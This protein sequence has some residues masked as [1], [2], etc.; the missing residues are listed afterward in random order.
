MT[1]A[2]FLRRISTILYPRSETL[3]AF[4]LRVDV[5]LTFRVVSTLLV[6]AAVLINLLS[7]HRAD[8]ETLMLYAALAASAMHG[9]LMGRRRIEQLR[10]ALQQKADELQR[11]LDLSLDMIV[12]LTRNGV[13]HTVNQA[14]FA[15]LGYRPE[16]LAGLHFKDVVHPSGRDQWIREG[17]ALRQNKS[18]SGLQVLCTRKDGQMV[19][20]EW[21]AAP[22]A[23]EGLIYAVA[24][25]ITQRKEQAFKLAESE[26]RLRS[27][28]TYNLDLVASIDLSGRVVS[29]NP[30]VEA[31]LGY[32]PDEVVGRSF[33]EFLASDQVDEMVKL[34]QRS[35]ERQTQSFQT[36]LIHSDGSRRLVSSAS[37]P[38]IVDGQLVGVYVIVRDITEQRETEQR[39]RDQERLYRLLA[40]NSRDLI[41]LYDPS[42]KPQFVSPASLSMMGYTP[43]EY[44]RLSVEAVVHPEDSQRVLETRTRHFRGETGTVTFR[45]QRKDGEYIWIETL[46]EPIFD[47]EGCLL[48]VLS[49]SRD[50]T[51]R[52]R[53]R[54]QLEASEQRFRSL[55][56]N[57]SDVVMLFDLKGNLV[58][59]NAASEALTGYSLEELKGSAYRRHL[60]A[61]PVELSD[62]V[63]RPVQPG[64]VAPVEVLYRHKIGTL[65]RF[66]TT[67]VPL[68]IEG[69]MQGFFSVGRDVTDMR[70]SEERVR[71]LA[72]AGAVLASSLDYS[73]TLSSMASLVVEHLADCCAIDMLGTDGQMETVALVHRQPEIAESMSL[74]RE[75]VLNGPDQVVPAMTV[76]RTGQ[77]L[78]ISDLNDQTIAWKPSEVKHQEL[79]QNLGMTSYLV[80]P[81]QARGRTMGTISMFSSSSDRLF[82]PA[83]LETGL[84]LAGRAALA[85]DNALLY[86]K[87]NWAGLHDPLTHLPNRNLLHEHLSDAFRWAQ[88][89]LDQ[90]FALLFLDLDSF[91]VVNDSLGHHIGDRLLQD[92]AA[93]IARCAGPRHLVARIGGDEFVVMMHWVGDTQEPVVLADHILN[94]FKTPL[95]VNGHAVVLS[96][97]IGIVMGTQARDAE[98]MIRC[99]DIAMYE[100]K[101]KG[102][103]RYAVFDS[104]MNSMAIERL[105]LEI[106]LRR[107]LEVQ[108]FELYFQPIIDLQTGT[109]AGVEALVRW[110]HPTRGIVPPLEFIPITEETGLIVELGAWILREACRQAREWQEAL[111]MPDLKVSVNLSS[112]QIQAPDVVTVVDQALRDTGLRPETLQLEITESM[113]VNDDP[114]TMDTIVAL[115]NLG[116]HLAVDD[117]GTGYSALNYLKR[118]PIQ[119]LKIDRS[120]ITGISGGGADAA[121]VQAVITFAKA[122][123]LRV[124]AEG[125]EGREQVEALLALG[126]D[127]AQ[128]FL[129]SR[130]LP[131]SAMLE[132]LTRK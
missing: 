113:L 105:Q 128:G 91:K 36:A 98:D 88:H 21:T 32:R 95:E 99:A 15:L 13:F 2:S 9:L 82:G 71:F 12:T 103:A 34:F 69:Q 107:A 47:D 51:E 119:S 80:V 49:T 38:I 111:H 44:A 110:R 8:G 6:V 39:M 89:E 76:L 1:P 45:F 121:I 87:A 73:A 78:L 102:K 81:L 56:E 58:D 46:S 63:A 7:P 124:V 33:A 117:F 59:A 66:H 130:P 120:F 25:D 48:Q 52:M 93:R 90:T 22:M 43:E 85:I 104:T 23:G 16:E 11:N 29:V 68:M 62:H 57:N 100:A 61:V 112:R 123:N 4:F 114:A 10:L 3:R 35:L 53:F 19:W 18:V 17:R 77:P 28:F 86:Q 30:A 5:V 92:A 14:S 129:F 26:Q 126:C 64:K 70:Q 122:L 40:E 115:R 20:L 131:A 54:A 118:F 96:A 109:V 83:D 94:A 125:V 116:V 60:V 72:K 74:A 75:G 106:D 31:M 67:I 24:R 55:F 127:Q 101:K 41:C 84:E 97:S 108:E 132:L 42:G 27:L 50:V 65:R 79:M 37:L